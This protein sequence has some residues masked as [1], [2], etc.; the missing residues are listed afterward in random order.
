MQGCFVPCSLFEDNCLLEL[1]DCCLMC[2]LSDKNLWIH[3]LGLLKQT[4]TEFISCQTFCLTARR[5][6]LPWAFVSRPL[7]LVSVDL[8][9]HLGDSCQVRRLFLL[10]KYISRIVGNILGEF[11]CSFCPSHF[12]SNLISII[13]FGLSPSSWFK[14]A[15]IFIL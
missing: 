2:L 4:K 10:R 14:R 3:L 15:R 12:H 11:Q 5:R 1:L 7:G 13:Q 8:Q 6:F 9:S